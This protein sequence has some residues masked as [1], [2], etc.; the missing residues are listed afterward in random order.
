MLRCNPVI[1]LYKRF[2]KSGGFILYRF[3]DLLFFVLVIIAGFPILLVI[4]VNGLFDTG[5]QCFCKSV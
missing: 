4:Y 5:S 3:V 2:Y 1:L